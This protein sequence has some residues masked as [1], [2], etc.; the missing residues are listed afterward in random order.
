MFVPPLSAGGCG[1]Q[2]LVKQKRAR[3]KNLTGAHAT[4]V[5]VLRSK[6][7]L[8]AKGWGRYRNQTL[9]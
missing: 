4:D 3:K 9:S 6:T 5:V 8:Y 7:S 1:R 2:L